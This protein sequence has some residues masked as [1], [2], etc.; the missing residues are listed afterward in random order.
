MTV[1]K[2]NKNSMS[3]SSKTLYM[4]WKPAASR[5]TSYP[6]PHDI[7]INGQTKRPTKFF[8]SIITSVWNEC[9]RWL[10]LY[11]DPL[12]SDPNL[13]NTNESG[14]YI[15][16][17]AFWMLC[18]YPVIVLTFVASLSFHIRIINSIINF[19]EAQKPF[20]HWP[21]IKPDI[22]FIRH[23][24]P[25]TCLCMFLFTSYFFRARVWTRYDVSKREHTQKKTLTVCY[26]R[27]IQ[28]T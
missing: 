18:V 24:L 10:S 8:I 14:V 12:F 2:L 3:T 5:L 4:F 11:L 7:R 9:E 22:L 17:H 21:H 20:A 25:S 26:S 28:P 13:L 27:F 19:I 1:A 16:V 6:P 23:P 15:V